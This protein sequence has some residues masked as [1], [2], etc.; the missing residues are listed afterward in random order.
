M[1][2]VL[3]LFTSAAKEK[4]GTTSLYSEHARPRPNHEIFDLDLNSD[5]S[6]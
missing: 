3:P 5:L 2:T 6:D 1:L 4:A